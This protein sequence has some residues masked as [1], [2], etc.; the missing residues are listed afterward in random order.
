[1][2]RGK[3]GAS[4]LSRHTHTNSVE[5]LS[6][7]FCVAPQNMLCEHV[8]AFHNPHAVLQTNFVFNVFPTRLPPVPG[9]CVLHLGS[10]CSG[11]LRSP[12]RCLAFISFVCIA[13][14]N[15]HHNDGYPLS[16]FVIVACRSP[17]STIPIYGIGRSTKPMP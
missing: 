4:L 16:H 11:L 7:L 10:T 2:Q 14:F 12:R 17:G 1:M 8:R 13:S 3:G 9:W 6:N 5:L 15:F